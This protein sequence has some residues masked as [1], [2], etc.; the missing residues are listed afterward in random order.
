PETV[1]E[2]LKRLELCPEKVKLLFTEGVMD[3]VD[4][5]SYKVAALDQWI[6]ELRNRIVPGMRKIIR[7]CEKAHDSLDCADIDEVRW[8]KV[9]YMRKD[10]GQDTTERISLLTLL[11]N[12]LD[13]KDYDTASDLQILAQKKISN[14]EALY[15]EYK[16]NLL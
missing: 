15:A 14:L 11:T 9:R 13:D 7:S 2:V 6:T 16:K 8:K 4:L 1:W 3:P 5:E 10:M 12:A